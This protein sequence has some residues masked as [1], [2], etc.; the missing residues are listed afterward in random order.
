MNA[1]RSRLVVI[2]QGADPTIIVQDG[3]ITEYPV[4]PISP[5]DIV[6]TNGA[7]D[8]F[9]GGFLSRFVREE[10]ISQCVAAGNYLANLVIQRSG[11]SYPDGQPS[12]C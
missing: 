6:D 4:I 2:T 11:A 9:V 10:P 3:K 5:K 7:G 12:F 8:A 1:Q